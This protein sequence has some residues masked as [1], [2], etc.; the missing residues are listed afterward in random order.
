MC[1]TFLHPN[2]TPQSIGLRAY[3]TH[4]VSRPCCRYSRH[5]P[6]VARYRYAAWTSHLPHDPSHGRRTPDAAGVATVNHHPGGDCPPGPEHCTHGGSGADLPYC[7]HGRDQ[8]SLYLPVG[9]SVSARGSGG[10]GSNT[11]S[12]LTSAL[13]GRGILFAE[14]LR[15]SPVADGGGVCALPW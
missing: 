15:R 9:A 4:Q 11:R 8:P 3:V 6:F 1:N 13:T 2:L 5:V 10:F 7:R 14:R 12:A